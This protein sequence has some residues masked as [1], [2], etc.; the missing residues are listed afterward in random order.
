MTTAEFLDAVLPTQGARCITALV[1][2]G[3]IETFKANNAEA[4]ATIARSDARG[5]PT[6]FACATYTARPKRK[7]ENVQAVKAFWVDVD[8]GAGK[9]YPNKAAGLVAMKAALKTIGLPMPMI[10]DSGNGLHLYWPL[11]ADIDRE[12][13]QG[14]ARLL[15][16]AVRA[17]GLHADPTRTADVASIL[18]PPG[19]YNRK[20]QANPL[21]V[22]VL[23]AGGVCKHVAIHDMLTA[24]LERAGVD[25]DAVALPAKADLLAGLGAMPEGVRL[26]ANSNS[27]LA[28]GVSLGWFSDLPDDRKNACLA[29]MLAVPDVVAVADLERGEWLRIVMACAQSGAP[30]AEQLCREWSQTSARYEAGGFDR[31]WQSASRDAR[32]ITIGTLISAA[33]SAGWD[34]SRWRALNESADVAA[35]PATA[36]VAPL[37]ALDMSLFSVAPIGTGVP[38]RR[39]LLGKVL[40]RQQYTMIAAP[41]GRGKSALAIAMALSA[42]TGRDLLNLGDVKPAKVLLVNAE[43]GPDELQRR[44]QAA[45]IYYKISD[46]DVAGRI[47]AVGAGQ[48]QGMTLNRVNQVTR[49]GEV[50]VHGFALLESMIMQ[51]GAE[52]VI[53]DPLVAMC[54]AGLND[55]AVAAAVM[56]E[57]TQLAVRLDVA[58]LIVHH[59]R[60]GT[61]GQ[62]ASQEDASGAAAL[63]NLARIGLGI[64]RP[65]ESE[66]LKVGIMPADARRHFILANTKANLAPLLE[67]QWF[68]LETVT[69]ANADP[70]AGYPYGDDVQVVAPFT[71]QPIGGL[72]NPPM[73]RAVAGRLAQGCKAGTEPFCPST[74]AK[75][76][77]NFKAAI[78]RALAVFFPNEVS[79]GLERLAVQGV[80]ELVNRGMLSEVATPRSG[81]NKGKGL[82]VKWSQS[83]WAVDEA[84]GP[85]AD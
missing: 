10:V 54:P 50:N 20:D 75:G 38:P 70:A 12:T 28:A 14:T 81:R 9:P 73:L 85:F 32:S 7:G 37:S 62:A 84:P 44:M 74:K 79:A 40:I 21:E 69:L 16:A 46:A 83:P 17:A 31:D 58:V 60:K 13:W 53:L 29:E 35:A 68:Q 59:T 5:L 80:A 61:L 24:Y 3:G 49:Q 45:A 48:V 23:R 64:E 15:K 72:F 67:R 41:G 11:T 66:A 25:P 19:T 63:V 6:Y 42:A 77:T 82:V 76:E 8:C 55:N 27:D 43:D 51:S 47:F 33:Q 36:P 57:I 52:I 78:G 65:E 56:R 34:A 30:D 1:P 4:A 18:R 26:V 71:P 39:W 2:T 22:K